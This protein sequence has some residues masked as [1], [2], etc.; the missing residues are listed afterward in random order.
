MR[1]QIGQRHAILLWL[2]LAALLL[3]SFVLQT[4]LHLP[5]GSLP[6]SSRIAAPSISSARPLSGGHSGCPLCIELKIA[7]HYL[8]ATP[9]VLIA[10]PSLAFWFY[11]MV[12]VEPTRP[13]PTHHWQSRAP[14]RRPEL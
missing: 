11:R 12:T 1:P 14:P 4:H 10:P 2:S 3:Q 5:S 7:G 13:Q 9:F 8:P 6:A